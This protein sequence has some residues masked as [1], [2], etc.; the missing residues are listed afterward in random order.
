MTTVPHTP[1]ITLIDLTLWFYTQLAHRA[2]AVPELKVRSNVVA[3]FP[4]V[5]LNNS[6][7]KYEIRVSE[8]KFNYISKFSSIKYCRIG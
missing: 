8:L 4:C 5:T 1:V 2:S 6:L 7:F 3:L